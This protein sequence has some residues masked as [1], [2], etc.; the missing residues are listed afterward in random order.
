MQ[1]YSNTFQKMYTIQLCKLQEFSKTRYVN[2]DIVPFAG[3]YIIQSREPI[4]N[5]LK[6]YFNLSNEN[7]EKHL[8]TQNQVLNEFYQYSRDLNTHLDIID[9][10]E[11]ACLKFKESQL[12]DLVKKENIV[13]FLKLTVDSVP[14]AT[15]NQDS[16]DSEEHLNLVLS[17][18]IEEL[19]T[20]D[21]NEL[22]TIVEDPRNKNKKIAFNVHT[23]DQVLEKIK[24][25]WISE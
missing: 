23:K 24:D 4:M 2:R 20:D 6:R 8:V 3:N 1:I 22:K 5:Y 10:V 13:D 11:T 14:K 25:K 15:L 12:I 17:K 7:E 18:Q 19:D 9:P 16:S 21:L